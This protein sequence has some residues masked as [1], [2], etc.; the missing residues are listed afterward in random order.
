MSAIIAWDVYLHG[1][2]IDTIFFR[3]DHQRVTD[4]SDDIRRSL[5]N[6]DGYDPGIAVRKAR[7]TRTARITTPVKADA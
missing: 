1:K 7:S 4:Q 2:V 6:H 5:I 3:R